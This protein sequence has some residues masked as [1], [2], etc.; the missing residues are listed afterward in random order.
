MIG[1]QVSPTRWP[2]ALIL[3]AILMVFVAAACGTPSGAELVQQK[4]TRCHTIAV[5]QVS[6]KTDH[7]WL[8]TVYRMQKLGAQVDDEQINAIVDY[9]STASGPQLSK[10]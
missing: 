5:I 2:Y 9:L 3:I 1:H 10:P 7:E 8:N 4:C 6:S